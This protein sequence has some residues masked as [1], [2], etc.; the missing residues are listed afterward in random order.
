MG[1][2]IFQL[3]ILFSNENTKQADVSL[4]HSLNT[5]LLKDHSVPGSALCSGQRLQGHS[6]GCHSQRPQG[7]GCSVLLDSVV[8]VAK[9]SGPAPGT[10]QVRAL[11][12]WILHTVEGNWCCMINKQRNGQRRQNI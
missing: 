11:R 5:S 12:S 10:C 2:K 1:H 4:I 7:E 9:C 8:C 3:L 6:K